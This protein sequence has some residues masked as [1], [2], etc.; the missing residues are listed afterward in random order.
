MPSAECNLNIVEAGR[1]D[2]IKL[3]CSLNR[4]YLVPTT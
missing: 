3:F 2:S 4:T 1:V